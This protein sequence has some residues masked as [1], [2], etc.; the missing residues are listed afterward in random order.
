[1]NSL[2][3]EDT[4]PGTV[5]IVQARMGSSRLPGKVLLQLC[6]QPVLLHI[7]RRLQRS[8]FVR[9]VVVATSDSPLDDIIATRCGDWGVSSFR[10]PEQDV[11]KRFRLT[12]EA[13]NA[14]TIVRVTADCPF[15]DVDLLDEALRRFSL[16]RPDYLSNVIE[17]RTFPKGFDLEVFSMAALLKADREAVTLYDREHVTPY[18]RK[19]PHLFQLEAIYRKAPLPDLNLCL[20]SPEDFEFVSAIYNDIYY[21]FPEFGEDQILAS[22]PVR[23]KLLSF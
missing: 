16:L 18:I 11:L 12:A 20:D 5:V 13:V 14:E 4:T 3:L 15:A 9:E 17:P 2:N 21:S 19:N 6:G 10:G 7:V 8:K 1:M 22:Q 23:T